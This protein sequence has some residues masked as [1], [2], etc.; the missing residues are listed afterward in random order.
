MKDADRLS[1]QLPVIYIELMIV[2]VTAEPPDLESVR[3]RFRDSMGQKIRQYV[4][5]SMYKL[6]FDQANLLT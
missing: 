2:V 4:H 3:I 6:C 5:K 1:L